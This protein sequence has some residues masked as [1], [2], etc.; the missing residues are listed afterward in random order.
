MISEFL[1]PVYLTF[2]QGMLFKKS[3]ELSLNIAPATARYSFI[4]DFFWE[5]WSQRR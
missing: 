3:D 2:E 4:N 1:A 5:I